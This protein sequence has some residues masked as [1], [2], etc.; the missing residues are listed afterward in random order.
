MTV[1][2]ANAPV[3]ER[4]I[5]GPIRMATA[6]ESGVFGSG[7]TLDYNPVFGMYAIGGK[8]VAEAGLT[9]TPADPADPVDPA[10]GMGATRVVE[11]GVQL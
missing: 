9:I 6:P 7:N 10:T 1:G 4:G 5:H 8:D 3:T 11:V 2:V